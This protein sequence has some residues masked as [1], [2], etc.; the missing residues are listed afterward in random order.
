MRWLRRH[1]RPPAHITRDM[2]LF[3]TGLAGIAYETIVGQADRP[4]LL[5]LFGG[6]VGLPAFLAS[7]ERN[8]QNHNDTP[9]K[10]PPK[11]G[12]ES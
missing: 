6:M 4:T 1:D 2:I 8:K 5:I 9:P 11:G 12:D 3:I 7:D 10:D